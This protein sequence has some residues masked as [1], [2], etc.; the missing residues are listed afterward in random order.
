VALTY[1]PG[2]V[3]DELA[4]KQL[5]PFNLDFDIPNHT[6]SSIKI[7]KLDIKVSDD[8]LFTPTWASLGGQDPDSQEQKGD[9]GKWL[10]HKT[11]SGSYVCRV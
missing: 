2:V 7:T 5:G 6:V 8:Y 3:L 1:S 4:F 9:P 11:F 10:R